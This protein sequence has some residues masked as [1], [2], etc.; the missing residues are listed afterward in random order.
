MS[1]LIKPVVSQMV[2]GGSAANADQ[3]G[4]AISLTTPEL[5]IDTVVEPNIEST[6]GWDAYEVWRRLIKDARD[7]RKHHQ[8][9]N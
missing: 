3:L 4:N 8:D 2:S 1:T 9:S 7:R 5:G 6:G